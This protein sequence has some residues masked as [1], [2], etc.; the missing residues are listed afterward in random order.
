M[1]PEH[2][3]FRNR[4]WVHC[5]V[6][7][8]SQLPVQLQFQ[9][10]SLCIILEGCIFSEV[11]TLT[12]EQQSV[13]VPFVYCT[14]WQ[15]LQ[16]NK[17]VLKTA[18]LRVRRHVIFNWLGCCYPPEYKLLSFQYILH[19]SNVLISLGILIHDFKNQNTAWHNGLLSAG[20]Y[21]RY[22]WSAKC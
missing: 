20:L 8:I 3:Y 2:K 11:K 18:I 1:T 21:W 15:S 4:Y 22:C 5:Q 6:Y 17:I 9:S 12:V 7:H 19:I 10:L 14:A 13:C 16:N